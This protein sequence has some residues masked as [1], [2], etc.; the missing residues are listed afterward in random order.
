MTEVTGEAVGNIYRGFPRFRL[1][2]YLFLINFLT[3][4]WMVRLLHDRHVHEVYIAHTRKFIKYFMQQPLHQ[5][6]QHRNVTSN[7]QQQHIWKSVRKKKTQIVRWDSLKA[8]NEAYTLFLWMLKVGKDLSVEEL[9][10]MEW[11]EF[12]GAWRCYHCQ[13]QHDGGG[14]VIDYMERMYANYII[15]K[16][17]I[18]INRYWYWQIRAFTFLILILFYTETLNWRNLNN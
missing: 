11:Y 14:E 7:R 15:K 3:F 17:S 10:F 13:P 8:R 18:K 5:Q 16:I 12:D 2:I 4:P 6:Q 9:F 1:I